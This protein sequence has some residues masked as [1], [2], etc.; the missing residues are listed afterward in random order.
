M[1]KSARGPF[2]SQCGGTLVRKTYATKVRSLLAANICQRQRKFIWVEWKVK[3]SL[4]GKVEGFFSLSLSPRNS[5]QFR[6]SPKGPFPSFQLPRFSKVSRDIFVGNAMKGWRENFR[7]NDD[8][9]SSFSAPSAIDGQSR[10]L[11]Y[12][13]W[14][15]TPI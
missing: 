12:S 13:C 3:F 4:I 15:I 7:I 5:P 9:F 10:G 14:G 6:L 8:R 11:I 1:H 2:G